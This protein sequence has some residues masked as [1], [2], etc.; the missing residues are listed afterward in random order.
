MQWEIWLVPLIA[1]AVW[2]LG[3][4]MRGGME[5]R[6]RK[7]G[8]SEGGRQSPQRSGS[9]LELFL[10]EVHRRRQTGE[11]RQEPRPEE[12]P[13]PKPIP[14]RRPPRPAPPPV[15]KRPPPRRMVGEA[16]VV[17]VVKAAGKRPPVVLQPTVVPVVVE[18]VIPASPPPR[19][20]PAPGTRRAVKPLPASL[21]AL[22][23]S[24]AALRNAM[25]L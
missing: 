25:I 6:Q 11:P 22:L 1:I 14:P 3:S 15:A 20:P 12:P 19:T 10:Q 24:P 21:A 2:I 13:K 23:N 18:A 8:R 5:E 9:D 4:L 16:V 7:S 17:E